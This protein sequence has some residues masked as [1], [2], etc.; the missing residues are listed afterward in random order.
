VLGKTGRLRLSAAQSEQL[1]AKFQGGVKT[2]G[3]WRI[4]RRLVSQT[5][6]L[7]ATDYVGQLVAATEEKR[8]FTPL[9]RCLLLLSRTGLPF[10]VFAYC[11]TGKAA[12]DNVLA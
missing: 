3:V 9:R 7:E 2:R 1:R 10:K 5:G 8:S 4:R 11:I 12:N 6:H